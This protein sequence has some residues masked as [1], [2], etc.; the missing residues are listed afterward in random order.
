VLRLDDTVTKA[1]LGIVR[2]QLDAFMAREAR[3]LAERDGN[4]ALAFPQE[5][6]RRRDDETTNTAITGEEKLFQSRR[7]ALT[8][9]RALLQERILQSNEEIRG[10]VAQQ[11][12]KEG[13]LA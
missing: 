1:N 11:A 7:T 4:A 8:G 6:I 12:A 3:L 10:L 5:L 9:Q 13:E 2:S